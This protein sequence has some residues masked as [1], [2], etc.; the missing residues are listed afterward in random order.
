MRVEGGAMPSLQYALPAT[1][2][3]AMLGGIKRRPRGRFS[4]T[5]SGGR[6]RRVS[7]AW[8]K[9]Y[10]AVDSSRPSDGANLFRGWQCRV[11]Q[12]EVNV[13]VSV[14]LGVSGYRYKNHTSKYKI[15]TSTASQWFAYHSYNSHSSARRALGG[16]RLVQYMRRNSHVLNWW[17]MNHGSG[18][19]AGNQW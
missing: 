10:S 19:T 17:I 13:K 15:H 5:R 12:A 6:C 1:R 7:N 4:R 3:T 11:Q 2:G 9:N 8:S 14:S 16:F 18:G